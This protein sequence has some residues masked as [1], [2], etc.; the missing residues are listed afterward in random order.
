[1]EH[2][3]LG[4]SDLMVSVLG[5]GTTGWGAHT[6]FGEVDSTEAKRQVAIALDAGINPVRH[7]GDLRRRAL[8]ADAR[9]RV[10]R[11]SDEAI[12][13]TV[14]NG[15]IHRPLPGFEVLPGRHEAGNE[16]VGRGRGA[17]V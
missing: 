6:E 7:R 2:R 5:L 1:M 15:S 17:D 14:P 12:I 16:T 10:Q 9:R 13:A 4:G 11:P 3:R 8:R